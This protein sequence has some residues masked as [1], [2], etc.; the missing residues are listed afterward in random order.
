MSNKKK[1]EKKSSQKKSS[2]EPEEAIEEHVSL[3]E[4]EHELSNEPE[5]EDLLENLEKDYKPIIKL[6]EY[7]KQEF[8]E[9]QY[10][11]MTAEQRRKAE[12]EIDA[13]EAQR[14]FGA[15][16][17]SAIL[18]EMEGTDEEEMMRALR[19]KK[20]GFG[21]M[22]MTDEQIRESEAFIDKEDV[23]GKLMDWLSQ[24]HAAR[25]IRSLFQKF[26]KG[27][28]ED[29]NEEIY[30]NRIV[31]MSKANRQSLEINYPH[32]SKFNK[33]LSNWVILH[34]E[35]IL[36]YLNDVAFELTC[37]I[38]PR[39]SDICKEIFV[40]IRDI[41][42][43]I[44][45]RNLKC[46]DI[47]HL[48]KING[49]VTKRS[50]VYPKLR[51]AYFSCI[52]CGEINGPFNFNS[53]DGDIINIGSCPM[54]Q[55]NGPYRLENDECQY[56]NYQRITI[57]ESPGSVP[58]G[59]VPRQ[60]EVILTNDLVDSAR[61]GDSVEITGIYKS[62]FD[63]GTNVKHSFPVFSTFIEANCIKRLNDID[64][65]ELTE[66]D[67]SEMK[68]LAKNPNITQLIFNSIAPSIY[69]NEF[70]KKA[71]AIAMF[72]GVQKDPQN[73]HK[74]RGDIN[75]LLLGDP[76]TSKSQMLKYVQTIFSRS[77]YTTGKGASAV[78]LTAS[79]Q[80]DPVTK[81]WTLEGG[82]LV[83]AD[84]G[85]CLIDEFDKMNDQDRTSIHE[86]MEQQSISI[87]KVGIVTSLQARCSVIAA[88]NPIKGRYDSRLSFDDNVELTDPILS[89]FDLLCVVR[90]TIDPI[91]D[92]QL[93]TFV[94]NSHINS[95]PEKINKNALLEEKREKIEMLEQDTLKKYIIYARKYIT[96]KLSELNKNKVS[97]FYSELRSESQ[98]SGGIPIAVRHLE[99]ILRIAEAHAKMQLR[100]IVRSDDIDFSIQMMLQSF[101]QSQ[102]YSI[103]NSLTKKFSHYLNQNQDH[104]QLLLNLLSKK[105]KEQFQYLK[106]F[107][108]ISD[109]SG[110]VKIAKDSFEKDAAELG[111]HDFI[112]FYNSQQ[113]KTRNKI[114]EGFIICTL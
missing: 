29:Q 50:S 110:E 33:Y 74:I 101:L 13:R 104:N 46:E 21:T 72:G 76:G 61:P 97:K 99:S 34:P 1:R 23:K 85:I 27:Y 91:I 55:S 56:R 95:H 70:I 3:S 77:V 17:P 79:V 62:K 84:K 40:R 7:E 94:I 45:L 92:E 105:A 15:R 22:R 41:P 26:I 54:C 24:P 71:L 63:I 83:L 11:N 98:K 68:K 43:T 96:P 48:I 103:A 78:G 18:A 75:V 32:L 88:A 12:R 19:R 16:I 9:T 58:A 107:N 102:K 114:E 38:F 82:A 57:Q 36:P 39:Y 108:H 4:S 90:D 30:E 5:G 81:E 89:R 66:D 28:R 106:Y 86:A 112:E 42:E 52:K 111:I 35:I 109:M 47:G 65:E 10:A 2:Q 80:K 53:S 6:D 100:E 73:K 87:S 60:K 31:E 67:K 49:V 37:E 59:R 69:G 113:F 44:N 64:V 93:A 25:F 20:M 14:R 51:T 8:D